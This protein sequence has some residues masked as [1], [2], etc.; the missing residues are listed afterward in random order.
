MSNFD[1]IADDNHGKH[2]CIVLVLDFYAFDLYLDFF[3][4]SYA[5]CRTIGNN[6]ITKYCMHIGKYH[7]YHTQG[8]GLDLAKK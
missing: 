6:H 7:I 8:V 1:V 4:N 2:I 3:S 5:A